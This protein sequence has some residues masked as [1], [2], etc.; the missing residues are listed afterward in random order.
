MLK[1]YDKNNILFDWRNFETILLDMDGTLLDLNFDNYF[2]QVL[3]PKIYSKKFFISEDEAIK[4]IHSMYAKYQG[5]LDWYCLEFWS[6]KLDLDLKELKYNNRHLIRFLPGVEKF[7]D[8]MK[9]NNK[10]IVLVTN[11]HPFAL[12]IKKSHVQLDKWF[13]EFISSHQYGVPKEDQYF[14]KKLKLQ[15]GF[16]LKST[17]FFDDSITVLDAAR[18][19][20]IG[21]LVAIRE[22]SSV[23]L[24][25]NIKEYQSIDGLRSLI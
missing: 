16:S 12:E 21:G 15:L 24:P 6:D 20:R 3:I 2:W 8:T 11:A 4:N 9:I 18:K 17:L 14:W 1:K 10:R 7:L 19:F 13:E 23:C 22:P 5:T 25:R